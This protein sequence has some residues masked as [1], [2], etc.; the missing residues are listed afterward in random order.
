MFIDGNDSTTYDGS[1]SRRQ[2]LIGWTPA[3]LAAYSVMTVP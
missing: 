2:K 1:P 3:A